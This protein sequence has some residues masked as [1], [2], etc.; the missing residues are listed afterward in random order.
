MSHQQLYTPKKDIKAVV[1]ELAKILDSVF[2]DSTKQHTVIQDLLDEMDN[3]G[4]T[5]SEI[6]KK[7]HH[8]E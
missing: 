4:K 8:N 6:D 5:K 2:P 7:Y 1:I 3:W